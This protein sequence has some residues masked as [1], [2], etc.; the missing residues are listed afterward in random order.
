[1]IFTSVI[2]L[3]L[4]LPIVLI[5]S[6][7]MPIRIRNVILLFASLFFY[8]WGESEIVVIMIASIL[9]NYTVGVMMNQPNQWRKLIL[10][11]GIVLNLGLLFWFKYFNFLFDN[12]NNFLELTGADKL[13]LDK[14]HLPIG[15]SFFTFQ[16]I[17]Y[18]VDVYRNQAKAQM[19]PIKIG[20]YISLFPQL[21]AGPIVRYT[22]IMDQIDKRR[23]TLDR[24]FEGSK[25]FIVG[26]AKKVIIANGAAQI[27]DAIFDSNVGELS[28][29]AAWVGIIAYTIQIYFDFSGY[30]DMAIGLGKILGFDFEENFN[31]PYV[32]RSIRDF[33]RRW[34]IS[35]STWFRDY[36]YIPL[37]GNKKGERRTYLNLLIVF[38][39]TGFWHGA[40]WSYMFWGVFHG[41]FLIIERL[42]FSAILSKM[43]APL[44]HLY[45]LLVV[46]I[47]WVFFR[48]EDITDAF[49]YL[50][51]LFGNGSDGSVVPFVNNYTLLALLLGFIFSVNI[52]QG[53]QFIET[54]TGLSR[55]RVY[56]ELRTVLYLFFLFLIF[57]FSITEIASD[58]YNPFIYLRF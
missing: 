3:F 54:S 40:S 22:D 11:I 25:R 53:I 56:M 26:F 27:A 18:I 33:W 7:A 28:S 41:M 30:S 10:T 19:N 55:F 1:M 20:L 45:L 23:T 4:F 17:S 29:L 12:V 47:G 36:L 52:K 34:H 21:I 32:A 37:G 16:G 38:I 8:S 24:L 15:I 51:V 5:A 35:L 57:F 42:G 43:I 9:L 44:Q 6:S 58:T 31:F 14:I 49:D 46:M 13:H 2:F 39:L 48:I 50:G